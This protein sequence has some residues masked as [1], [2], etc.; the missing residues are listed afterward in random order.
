MRLSCHLRHPARTRSSTTALP[1][2][3]MALCRAFASSLCAVSPLQH[4]LVVL[5]LSKYCAEFSA[6]QCDA[7]SRRVGHFLVESDPST[8]LGLVIEL[9][10]WTVWSGRAG[11]A[12]GAS[13]GATRVLRRAI[14]VLFSD[15]CAAPAWY[16]HSVAVDDDVWAVLPATVCREATRVPPTACDIVITTL[17]PQP[18]DVSS[19]YG[20]IAATLRSEAPAL[21]CTH[22]VS[23]L[24]FVTLGCWRRGD[25]GSGSKASVRVDRASPPTLPISGVDPSVGVPLPDSPVWRAQESFYI[26]EG[27][28]AWSDDVVGNT[29][30]RMA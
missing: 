28:S 11:D 3:S 2:S 15:A 6:G 24:A 23:V 22:V 25:A 19:A 17:F 7:F 16:A 30:Q 18:D 21:S 13:T 14:E 4:Y 5:R 8:R 26:S 29:L 1:L 12:A 10:R 20:H 27:L 9:L